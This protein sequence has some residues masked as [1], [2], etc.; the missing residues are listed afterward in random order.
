MKR[1]SWPSAR[2]LVLSAVVLL[3]PALPAQ[4]IDAAF[5]GSYN[6]LSLGSAPNLPTPYGGLALLAG[7]NNTLLIGGAA[8][9]PSGAIY[10]V[11]VTRDLG[12]HITGFSGGATLYATAANID[13]GLSYGPGGVLFYTG[14]PNNVLGQIKTGSVAPDK[15]TS[16]TGLG[17]AGSVGSMVF[18]PNGDLKLLSYSA[19]TWY[20]AG[21]TPDGS[22]TYNVGTA[23]LN[24]TLSGGLE[25]AAY[26]PNGSALFSNGSVLIAEY[27]TG[28]ISTYQTDANFD[29]IAATRQTFITGLS[30]AEGAFIDPVT[31]DF[32]FSTFGGSNQVIRVSGGFVAPPPPP[33]P[34]P[35][36][37]DGGSALAMF[38]AGLAMLGIL[39]RRFVRR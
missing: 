27:G 19:N 26:V 15:V 28:M 6:L 38:G 31:G 3:T 5:S 7:D 32:L 18:A 33:P 4:T 16:L 2:L 24:V 34:G 21:L 20:T 14:Y 17:V 36:V 25:G 11:G 29:P 10:S 9:G 37:P 12:G 8:N 23:T 22:G 1:S 30:G 13:G 35:G 39:R